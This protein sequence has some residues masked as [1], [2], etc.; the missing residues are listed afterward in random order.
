V[1]VLVAVMVVAAAFAML[2]M[3]MVVAMMP[4]IVPVRM[5][6]VRVMISVVV[7][8]GMGAALRPEWPLHRGRDAALSAHQLGDRRIVLHV[9][10]VGRDLDQPV[11]AAQMPGEPHEAQ[12][13]RA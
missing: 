9:E 13:G 6:V 11:L 1:L 12:R 8:A 2:V 10:G 5:T 7:P 3:G 4:V